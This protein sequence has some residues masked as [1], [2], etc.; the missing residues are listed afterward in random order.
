MTD[1][2]RREVSLPMGLHVHPMPD[3]PT[4]QAFMYGPWCWRVRWATRRSPTR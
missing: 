3:D 4:L 2:T 1:L